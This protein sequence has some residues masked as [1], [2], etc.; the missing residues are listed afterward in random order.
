M[1]CKRCALPRYRNL[2][3]CRWCAPLAKNAGPIVRAKPE[4]FGG[5][6]RLESL[7]KAECKVLYALVERDGLPRISYLIGYTE[8]TVSRAIAG[9]L[10]RKSTASN[11]RDYLIAE[12]MPK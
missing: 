6:G 9:E 7:T 8:P 2:D 5:K 10:V 1:T 12:G 4:P 11:I 3:T